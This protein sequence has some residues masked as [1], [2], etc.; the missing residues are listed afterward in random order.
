MMAT[1]AG[2]VASKAEDLYTMEYLYLY[3]DSQVWFPWP[4]CYR[5]NGST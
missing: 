2:A 3:N 5:N 4:C 1:G